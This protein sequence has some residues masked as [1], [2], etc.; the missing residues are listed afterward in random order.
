MILY[1][2]AYIFTYKYCLGYILQLMYI[3][4]SNKISGTVMNT[5]RVLYRFA[6]LFST[7]S[8]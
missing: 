2:Y 3:F 8:M 7:H 6:H 5:V 4:M 1:R